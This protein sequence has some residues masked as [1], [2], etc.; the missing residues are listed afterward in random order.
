MTSLNLNANTLFE[1]AD[2]RRRNVLKGLAAMAAASAA[3][4]PLKANAAPPYS[5]RAS[6]ITG[7]RAGTQA[8]MDMFQK[9]FPGSSV[10]LTTADVDQL[11]T[12]T[13]IALSAGTAPDLLTVWLG[14][15]NPLSIRQLAPGN[16]LEDLSGQPYASKLAKSLDPVTRVNGKLLVL[17]IALSFAGA[18]YNPKLFAERGLKQPK[19]WTEFLALCQHF[20]DAGII[21]IAVGNGTSWV[22]QLI[23]YSMLPSIVYANNPNFDRDRQEGK[24]KF[25]TSGW[26]ETLNKY[27]ELNKRGFFNPNP[28]G[29]SIDEAF[30]LVATG[31]AAMTIVTSGPLANLFKFAGHKNFTVMGVPSSD[32][33]S[34]FWMAASP[35]SGY[36]VNAKSAN[37]EGALAFLKLLSQPEAVGAFSAAAG[38]PAMLPSSPNPEIDRIYEHV[39]PFFREGRTTPMMDQSWPNARVQQIHNAGIQ[40]LLTGRTTVDALLK[41]MDEA[42][43]V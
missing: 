43:D 13:R 4:L 12:S 26:V 15:G 31:K 42:Y 3:G 2:V 1:V 5:L 27:M 40:E 37:K 38:V 25:A 18:V 24:V 16:F 33:P 28:V 7:A 41:R 19:T 32:D 8:V 34:K 11:F 36:A 9:S 22:N 29:T 39:M 20:K 21:P 6:T 10:N 35:S 14:N 17:P 30:Q 23:T